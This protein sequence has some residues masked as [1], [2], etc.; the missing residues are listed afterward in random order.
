MTHPDVL[1]VAVVARE[2]PKWGERA[3]AF[4]VLH[5]SAANKNSSSNGF[6][7]SLK[8]HAKERL[9]GFARPEWV[10]VVD[11]LP[12]VRLAVLSLYAST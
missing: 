6:E 2:H 5:S 11:D 12:K 8:S 1:E 9:P 3:H 10:E 4:V 7:E